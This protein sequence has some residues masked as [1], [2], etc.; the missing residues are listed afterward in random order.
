MRFPLST[1]YWKRH[2]TDS[3]GTNRKSHPNGGAKS[4]KIQVQLLSLSLSLF[5]LPI[6]KKHIPRCKQAKTR[7]VRSLTART[8]TVQ[9]T[10]APCDCAWV[11]R[12]LLS[13][14]RCFRH[15]LRTF[16]TDLSSHHESPPRS[17]SI[18]RRRSQSILGNIIISPSL[19]HSL[20]ISIFSSLSLRSN[21]IFAPNSLNLTL[22]L[23][24]I[25]KWNCSR[26]SLLD[27]DLWLTRVIY[28]FISFFL[29][30]LR[31]QLVEKRVC[32]ELKLRWQIGAE[33]SV[34]FFVE[35]LDLETCRFAISVMV[36]SEI[37]FLD[38]LFFWDT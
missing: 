20:S 13:Q 24:P 25:K 19:T 5:S 37:H 28:G 27:L 33:F 17:Q 4:T 29:V 2:C 16:S 7:K 22:T 26:D 23:R 10:H 11:L 30:W 36:F 32:I 6:L 3:K 34:I 31:I 21:L 35:D 12:Y 18:R 15:S 9:L 8:S 1:P 14:V 38:K